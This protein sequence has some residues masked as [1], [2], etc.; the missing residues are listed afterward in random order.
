MD[1]LLKQR[2]KLIKNDSTVVENIK[3]SVQAKIF[4]SD[5]TLPLEEGDMF[6]YVLPSGITQRLFVTK[7]TLF[8]FDSP[9]DH[10]EIEYQKE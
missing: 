2:L 6:E 5:I 10:Y 1:H 3:A 8:H 4:I 7:V 9:L